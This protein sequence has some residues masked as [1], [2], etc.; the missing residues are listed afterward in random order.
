[1]DERNPYAPGIDDQPPALGPPESD[2][3]TTDPRA[4]K[5]VVLGTLANFFTWL[6]PAA[7]IMGWIALS[8]GRKFLD[9]WVEY[10]H[11]R[12]RG[13]AIAG[14][15][16]GIAGIAFGIFFIFYYLFIF[17]MLYSKR[18]GGY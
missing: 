16:T 10:P 13:A 5:S 6:P 18:R 4:M 3:V 14:K 7:I 17:W 2:G 9:D 1:M 11:I 8:Q 15:I 12:G